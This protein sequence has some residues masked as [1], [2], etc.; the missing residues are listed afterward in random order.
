MLVARF[1]GIGNFGAPSTFLHDFPGP[2]N[3]ILKAT[4][5]VDVGGI[6]DQV[7]VIDILPPVDGKWVLE[8]NDDTISL[9]DAAMGYKGLMVIERCFRSLKRTQIKMTPMYHWLSRRI[10]AHVKI[11][12]LSLMIERIAERNCGQP[13]SKIARSLQKL[14]VTNLFYLNHRV[15]L[16]N[17][18]PADTRKILNKLKINP[19]NQLVHPKKYPQK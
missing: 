15:C 11:C 3:G 8:T 7:S 16:R 19:P 4:V 12:V 10:E 6:F 17:E 13:W 1:L 9:E 2:E 14:Q 5:T 18:V